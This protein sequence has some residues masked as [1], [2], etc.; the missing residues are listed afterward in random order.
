[1]C[2]IQETWLTKENKFSFK[3]YVTYRSER[4]NNANQK[5]GILA[6]VKKRISK[7][8]MRVRS[9]SKDIMWFK[10]SKDYFHFTKDIYI[11]CCYI[12]PQQS[13]YFLQGNRDAL[14]IL[15][16]EI[17]NYNGKGDIMLLGD[18]NC[19]TGEQKE[20]MYQTINGNDT[21]TADIFEPIV[22][23]SRANQDKNVN[24]NGKRL[25]NILGTNHLMI[26]NG[27]TPGDLDGKLTFCNVHGTSS[28]DLCIVS[29]TLYSS[30]M[31]FKV[32]P[33]VFYSDHAPIVVSL[34]TG[35]HN[36]TDTNLDEN[37]YELYRR[38]SW[39]NKNALIFNANIT[40]TNAQI[41]LEELISNNNLNVDEATDKLTNII[42]N[43]MPQEN[44]DNHK[45]A[46][47]A[48][49][50]QSRE[51]REAYRNY[52]KERR[53]FCRDKSNLNKKQQFL[54][55]KGKLRRLKSKMDKMITENKLNK[56]AKLEKTDIKHFWRE[57]KKINQC[58]EMSAD[59]INPKQWAVYFNKLLNHKQ[60]YD[61]N[62]YQ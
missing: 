12:V 7:G 21:Q 14:E 60:T 46:K 62:F 30:I 51:M 27:R 10:M 13:P 2:L 19:R 8:V 58:K 50:K 11:A 56:L 54:N 43:A 9:K 6:L 40:A 20:K 26:A 38:C 55:T 34:K 16:A 22:L 36:A 52:K 41:H 49:Q 29:H 37:S 47:N 15:E 35:K 45:P 44:L 57:L 24:K 28:I 61:E 53:A 1:M 59:I 5:G 25:I 18:T 4:S 33:F 42:L 32:L 3:G 48:K 39:N 17:V 31:Y 23:P